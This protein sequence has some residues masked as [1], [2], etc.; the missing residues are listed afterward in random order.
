MVIDTIGVEISRSP[1]IQQVLCLLWQADRYP[2]LG[3]EDNRAVALL[4][5]EAYAL[6]RHAVPSPGD[7]PDFAQWLALLQDQK[8]S[9]D[10]RDTIMAA[11]SEIFDADF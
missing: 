8:L 6:A 7:P 2:H 9:A 11:L 4:E 10:A 3:N 1:T 5:R